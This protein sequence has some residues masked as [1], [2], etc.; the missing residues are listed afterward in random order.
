MD[1]PSGINIIKKRTK[2]IK[3]RDNTTTTTNTLCSLLIEME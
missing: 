1:Q 3:N 2:T